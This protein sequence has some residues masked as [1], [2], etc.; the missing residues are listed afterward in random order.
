M[1]KIQFKIA[2][3]RFTNRVFEDE[4]WCPRFNFKS[5]K[6]VVRRGFAP[7]QDDYEAGRYKESSEGLLDH[8]VCTGI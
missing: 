6:R 3:V 2:W 7:W 4:N 1:T 5:F 8:P